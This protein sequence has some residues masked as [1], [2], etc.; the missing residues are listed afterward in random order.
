MPPVP[1]CSTRG[2]RTSVCLT[3]LIWSCGRFSWALFCA[4]ASVG[5]MLLHV[6]LQPLQVE[7]LLPAQGLRDHCALALYDML[8]SSPRAVSPWTICRRR[9]VVARAVSGWVRGMPY[10]TRYE[11]VSSPCMPR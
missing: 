10:F 11:R 8:A 7:L 6:D 2:H 4:A 3:R 5:W 9:S 1:S